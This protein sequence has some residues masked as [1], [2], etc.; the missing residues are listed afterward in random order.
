MCSV[1]DGGC[2]ASPNRNNSALLVSQDLNALAL[3]GDGGIAE[4]S[5]KL[6]NVVHNGGRSRRH[7]IHALG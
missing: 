4:S 1:A 7:I 6:E 3:S 2:A 5:D